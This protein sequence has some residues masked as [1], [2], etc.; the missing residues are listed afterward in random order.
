ML[1]YQEQASAQTL[2]EAL[3][4]YR[5]ANPRLDEARNPLGAAAE[6]FRCH[7]TAHVVFGCSTS[8]AGEALADAWTLFGTT[9]TVRQ[10]LGFLKIEEHQDIMAK[11][12]WWRALITFLRSVPLFLQVALRGLRMTSKWPWSDFDSYR[13]DSL[14]EIRR[15]FNIRVVRIRE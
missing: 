2:A 15:Q 11:V 5:A 7:D 8:L 10:F 13:D 6:F 3:A 9:V 1:K 14:A 12:G 4:E